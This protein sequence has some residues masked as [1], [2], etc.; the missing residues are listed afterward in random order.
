MDVNINQNRVQNHEIMNKVSTKE[1]QT[2]VRKSL[3][4]MSKERDALYFNVDEWAQST[5]FTT[6]RK[7]DYSKRSK[8]V[9][10]LIAKFHNV[11]G[12]LEQAEP[13]QEPEE[14]LSK[15]QKK[16]IK[17]EKAA[18]L[19]E[20]NMNIRRVERAN[21]AD[22]AGTIS[23]EDYKEEKKLRDE[24]LKVIEQS[25]YAA[26]KELSMFD[27]EGRL[28]VYTAAQKDRVKVR[29]H[30]ARILPAGSQERRRAM[31]KKEKSE[32]KLANL[33]R[34]LKVEELRRAGRKKAAEHSREKATDRRHFVM[35]CVRNCFGNADT[36]FSKED[37][38]YTNPLNQKTITNE[39]RMFFGGTKPMYLFR[40]RDAE[41]KVEK[42]YL[43]KEAV[44]CV[45]FK[46]PDRA[47]ATE[48]GSKVQKLVCGEKH[49]VP[50]FV[51]KNQNGEPIGT[52]QEKLVKAE[53][54][55]DLFEWQSDPKSTLRK[56][57]SNEILREHVLDWLLCNYDTK[58]EN[59]I[60]TADGLTS[61]D[62]EASF[63]YISKEGSRHMSMTYAPH[64][65]DT[66]YNVMFKRFVN[67]A[68]PGVMEELDLDSIEEYIT[69][70]EQ[71][72]TEE[73]MLIFKDMLTA[74]YGE[75]TVKGRVN[76][77]R[78]NVERM[79]RERKV[80]IRE[81]YRSFFGK[82]LVEKRKKLHKRSVDEAGDAKQAAVDEL[83]AFDNKYHY[84]VDMTDPEN[85]K[86]KF[87][88]EINA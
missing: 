88:S 73:Y 25:E 46:K 87:A 24:K 64:G 44:N 28:M 51:A 61:I 54:G 78:A 57:T 4:R 36:S 67:G 47:Y 35:A 41:G 65:N 27:I 49:Y 20:S 9:S 56:E 86:Y 33:N 68:D 52:F 71:Q 72:D 76:E 40:Q 50:A 23:R 81:E 14:G 13:I 38:S 70:V 48:A 43:Y 11:Q 45:G 34:M 55:F 66:I 2:G 60:K 26:L 59:F 84:R 69:K 32:I 3:D 12:P 1:L 75:V 74:R 17:L 29:T 37:V 79:I 30:F 82:M 39:G 10:K 83:Q 63:T 77:T 53:G 19:H 15:H 58:G 31:L 18:M 16:A 22:G 21:S 85:P 80:N 42:E 7:Y 6:K 5:K 8:K 62:K